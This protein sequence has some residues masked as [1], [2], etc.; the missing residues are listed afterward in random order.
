MSSSP[1][2][3]RVLDEVNRVAQ[4][5]GHVLIIGEPGTGRERVARE[6]HRRS[7]T[8]ERPFVKVTCSSDSLEAFEQNLFGRRTSRSA[9]R[10]ER[11]ALERVGRGQ[12]APQRDWRHHLLYESGRRSRSRSGQTYPI[13]PTTATRCIFSRGVASS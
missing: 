2:M 11:R 3:R 13:A 7:E 1:A 12:P 4:T 6:I 5:P 8:S 10:Q 9:E